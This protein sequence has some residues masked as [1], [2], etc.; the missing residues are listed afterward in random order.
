MALRATQKHFEGRGNRLVTAPAAEPVTAAELRT[1]LK[2]TG[3]ELP[4]AEAAGLIVEAREFIENYSGI[5]LINQTWRLTLDNWPGYVEPWWDGVREMAISALSGGA[6]LTLEF[7]RYPLSSV[8]S[9][10]TYNEGDAETIVNIATTFNIDTERRPG[11]MRLKPGKTWPVAARE[12][13]AIQIE[14]V[15]G[16]GATAGDVPA[17]LRSAVLALAAYYYDHRGEC[18]MTE[19]FLK[20]GAAESVRMHMIRGL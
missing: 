3:D 10:K 18:E 7:P 5:A 19:A 16:F 4:D 11:R 1:Q 6:P 14:Y 17:S 9:I 13:N 8:V 2:R 20:S 12:F 15:A